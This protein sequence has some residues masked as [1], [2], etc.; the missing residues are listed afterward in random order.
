[1][2]AVLLV[3]VKKKI[4]CEIFSASESS[5]CF[6]TDICLMGGWGLLG[7]SAASQLVA[8][9]ARRGEDEPREQNFNKGDFLDLY[10]LNQP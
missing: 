8:A 1:M 4:A 5:P 10:T 2:R 6:S 9:A 7:L 3:Y